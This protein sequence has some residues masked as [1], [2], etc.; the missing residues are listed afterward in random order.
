MFSQGY[1]GSA[2][3]QPFCNLSRLFFEGFVITLMLLTPTIALIKE[4]A[5]TPVHREIGINSVVQ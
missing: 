4:Y 1:Q 5:S 2:V 3:A